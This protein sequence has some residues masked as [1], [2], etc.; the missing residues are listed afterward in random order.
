MPNFLLLLLSSFLISSSSQFISMTVCSDLYFGFIIW[1]IEIIAL[2]TV[3]ISAIKN[4]L[5]HLEERSLIICMFPIINIQLA[6]FF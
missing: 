1:G 6:F 5:F 3:A 4:K 2:T